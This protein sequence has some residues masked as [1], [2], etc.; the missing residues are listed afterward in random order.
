MLRLCPP[1][2]T[3]TWV[4]VDWLSIVTALILQNNLERSDFEVKTKLNTRI[5]T[6][7]RENAILRKKADGTEDQQ[8]SFVY[9][10]EVSLQS[11][12]ALFISVAS[13]FVCCSQV[14]LLCIF[15]SL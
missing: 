2:N 1:T 15:F 13:S 7:E 3:S 12:N 6:L 8:K 10:L 9:S 4:C 5:D 14:Y 11:S